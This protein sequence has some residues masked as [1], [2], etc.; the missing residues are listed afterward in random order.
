VF[1]LVACASPSQRGHR[2]I[3]PIYPFLF[4]LIG[5]MVSE[6]WE[7]IHAR[8]FF[9]GLGLWQVCV[10]SFSGPYYISY[11]NEL[12]GGTKNGYRLAADSNTD[13]GQGLQALRR[14][15]EQEQV[16]KVYLSYFGGLSPAAYGIASAPVYGDWADPRPDIDMTRQRRQLLVVSATNL[17]SVYFSNK[18]AFD[19]LKPRKPQALLAGSLLV[20][21]I[22][23][24]AISHIRLAM[25]FNDMDDSP[26]AER[27]LRYG[28]ELAQNPACGTG[29]SF[30]RTLKE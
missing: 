11:F 13:W 29:R 4:V 25:I 23:C 27:E 6:L 5:L 15:M 14:Y 30:P 28:R 12:I 16:P 22:T 21:D 18:D 3:L 19:W 20:F 10:G 24:D 26:S 9:L 8:W 17:Q 7:K 1:F 2:H